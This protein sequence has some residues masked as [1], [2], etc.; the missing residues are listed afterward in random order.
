[1]TSQA[2]ALN[3]PFAAADI[4]QADPHVVA[5]DVSRLKQ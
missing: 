4:I 5:G 2:R 1:M 3:A